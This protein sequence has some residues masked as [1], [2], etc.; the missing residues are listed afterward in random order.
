MKLKISIFI[1][2]FLFA[3]VIFIYRQPQKKLAIKVDYDHAILKFPLTTLKNLRYVTDK[4][5]RKLFEVFSAQFPIDKVSKTIESNKN[6]HIVLWFADHFGNIS[7]PSL[8]WH[9]EH[10]LAPLK[11]AQT[12]FWLIDLAAW[13]FLSIKERELLKCYDFQIFM[14]KREHEK[15]S[16]LEECPLT[17]D[18]AADLNIPHNIP[19]FAVLR[20]NNFFK[21]LHGLSFSIQDINPTLANLLVRKVLRSGAARFSLRELGYQPQ[22]LNSWSENMQQNLLDIENT[23]IFPLLQYLEGIYYVLKIVDHCLDQNNEECNIV[24]LLANKEFTYYMI[25]GEKSPFET[26][27]CSIE[28]FILKLSLYQH[29]PKINIYFYPFSYGKGF[30][31]QS[32]EEQ[33]PAVTNKDLITLLKN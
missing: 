6:R 33:G 25:E 26:F 15:D 5:K 23:Q 28:S 11:S 21:W 13:R 24:F 4:D 7:K 18:M 3:V 1:I 27:R 20:S 9:K 8:L 31:D 17:T 2:T 30:Y 10:I 32:F 16:K 12:T 14:E 22:F 29:V 19:S